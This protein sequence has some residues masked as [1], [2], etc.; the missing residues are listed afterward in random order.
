MRNSFSFLFGGALVFLGVVFLL[1]NLGYVDSDWFLG[2]FWPLLLIVV[3][4]WLLARR[5]RWR[6]PSFETTTESSSSLSGSA[7]GDSTGDHISYSEVFGN[8]RREI[9]SKQFTGGDCSVV[10]GD[11]RLDLTRAELA[12]GE[13]VLRFSSVFG[14]IRVELPR[15][16][17]YSVRANFIAGGINVKGDRRGG[18][19]QNVAVRSNGYATAEKRLAILASSTFG[20][21]RIS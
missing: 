1:D 11:I 17:E 13:Q 10:F 20:D 8:I 14:N 15:D 6:H 5:S 3:G 9:T 21:I 19:F 18:I 7:A 4:I 16:V 2:N 12:P